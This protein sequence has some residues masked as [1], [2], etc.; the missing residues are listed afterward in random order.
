[1]STPFDIP[2]TTKTYPPRPTAFSQNDEAR[3]LTVT[4]GNPTDVTNSGNHKGGAVTE[5]STSIVLT[6]AN[7]NVFI[8]CRVVGELEINSANFGMILHR[9]GGTGGSVFLRANPPNVG[10]RGKFISPNV[11]SINND[12][13]TLDCCVVT[14]VDTTTS[15][16]TYTY[17]PVCV[18]TGGG[19]SSKEY[20]LN[21]V[22]SATNTLDR[23]V[24]ISTMVLQVI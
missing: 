13:T 11:I 23:E 17:T 7:Q 5:L 19:T 21:R 9:S 10:N 4:T 8:N 20:T 6:E 3:T 2:R 14:Y 1:M 15:A 24:A 18:N 16:D 22:V 12:V